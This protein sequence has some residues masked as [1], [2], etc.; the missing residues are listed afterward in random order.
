VA[1]NDRTG[2]R[3]TIYQVASRAGVSIATV[4]RALRDSDQ[5]TPA[6]RERIH[7]VI[8]E[9][10]YMPSRAGRALAEGRHAAHGIVFP[11]LT[12]P[13]FAEVVLGYEEVAAELGRSVLILATHGRPDA[14]R[15]ALELSGRVDGM[16]IALGTVPDQVVTRIAERGVPVV[17]VARAPLPG[18]DAV[19]TEN[20]ATA[21]QLADHLIEHGYTR[22]GFLGDPAASPDVAGRYAGLVDGFRAAGVPAPSPIRCAFDIDA[23]EAAAAE[24]LAGRTRPQAVV[25][26]NDELALG[27]LTAAERAGLRVPADL[28]V[29]GWDD[30]MAARF[31][32]LTTVRQ[33]MRELGATAARWL[34][35]RITAVSGTG[36]HP[37]GLHA[38]GGTAVE[39]PE[40]APGGAT[41]PASD[42]AYERTSVS[43]AGAR[44]EVLATSLVVRDSCG[45]HTHRAGSRAGAVGDK[46]APT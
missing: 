19:S 5:V 33:P 45:D 2:D 24:L 43:G 29:T 40:P 12:G 10:N 37:R 8:E 25:C 18:I 38:T 41:P 34:H 17:L 16:A 7:A 22:F 30:V 3:V 35:D 31:A 11:D 9:L 14:A 27:V 26:A 4:S 13:Y 36:A 23:G 21:R 32:R 28:A 39:G 6:T 42:L 15:Q 44:R 1:G 20:R 46:E